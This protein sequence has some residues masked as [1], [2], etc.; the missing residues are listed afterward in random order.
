MG[1]IS[2]KSKTIDVNEDG[3]QANLDDLYIDVATFFAEAEGIQMTEQH[4]DKSGVWKIF[5]FDYNIQ[6]I[7]LRCTSRLNSRTHKVST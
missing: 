5:I 2:V 7:V 4:C 1:T 3:F 6:R